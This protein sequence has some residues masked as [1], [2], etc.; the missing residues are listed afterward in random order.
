M[1]HDWTRRAIATSALAVLATLGLGTGAR[2]DAPALKTVRPGQLTIAYRTDDKPVSFIKDGKPTGF[3]VELNDAVAKKLGLKVVYVAT[4]FASMVPGVRNGRYDTAAF[5]MLESEKRAKI[6]D[7]TVP[8][9]YNQARLVTLKTARIEKVDGADGKTVA[10]TRGSAL[11]PK[12]EKI[13]PKVSVREF[14]NIAASL[15]AL[16]AHQVDGLFTGLSTANRLVTQHDQL[17]ASQVV[18]T[19]KAG[20]PVAK[21]NGALK[22]AYDKALTGLMTDG[23]FTSLWEKWHPA[24]VRIPDDLY[25]NYPGMPHQKPAQ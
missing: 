1:R 19:G 21:D 7:F 17:A 16:L 18:T 25:A 9:G 22:K 10:I 12:L 14:P 5:D 15:N 4:D 3:L 13:A 2:A 24:T 11:I 20:F 6:V 8:V 23:T